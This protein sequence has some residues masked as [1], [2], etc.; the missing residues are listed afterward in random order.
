MTIPALTK[1]EAKT[2]AA[3]CARFELSEPARALLADGLSPGEFLERLIAGRQLHD[4]IRLLAYSLPKREA[5]WWAARCARTVLAAAITP[6]QQA[7]LEATERWCAGP[8]EELRRA[9]MT[10]SE[11]AQLRNPAGCA[12]LA[13][14]FSGGSLAPPTAPVVPPADDLTPRTVAGA[15]LMAGIISQPEKAEQKYMQFL[16][17]GL[18]IAGGQLPWK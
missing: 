4:A 2:A 3:V 6:E 9:A 16:E 13:V 10:A 11:K 7:A 1:I 5:I 14:F 12:A 17:Q 8:S 15:I 18:A